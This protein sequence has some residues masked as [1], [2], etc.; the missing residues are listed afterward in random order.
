MNKKA[1]TCRAINELLCIPRYAA[2]RDG[3]PPS[4]VE[5]SQNMFLAATICYT[6]QVYGD[7]DM[8][9]LDSYFTNTPKDC[10]YHYTSFSSLLGIISNKEL[11]ISD[12]HYMNDSREMLQACEAIEHLLEPILAFEQD[13]DK[14]ALMWQ[15]GKWLSNVRNY[16]RGHLFIFSLSEQMSILSQWRSYTP[17]GKGVSIGFSRELLSRLATSPGFR[18][19]RCLYQKK[20]QEQ[21]LSDLLEKLWETARTEH[22]DLRGRY[23]I[24]K[25]SYTPVFLKHATTIYQV[26]ALVKHE[27]FSEER[28]WRLISPMYSDLSPC[29]FREGKSML[30]PY[31]KCPIGQMQNMFSSVLLGPTPHTELALESLTAYLANSKVC[32]TIVSCGIPYREW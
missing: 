13:S 15:F 29:N 25:Y 12:V 11:W 27:A 32:D 22:T 9:L 7:N 1:R 16:T 5:N 26:M 28:E 20:E 6:S 8:R 19:G 31:I 4:G 21:L 10:L 30:I 23:T 18:L 24:D 14:K 3:I 17:H 2:D